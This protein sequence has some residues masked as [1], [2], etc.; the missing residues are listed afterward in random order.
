MLNLLNRKKKFKNNRYSGSLLD[1]KNWWCILAQYKKFEQISGTV[2]GVTL[3]LKKRFEN[4]ICFAFPLTTYL[5]LYV[6]YMQN[7]KKMHACE[8]AGGEKLG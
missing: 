5:F 2:K 8:A 6:P 7:F 3:K 1:P 4:T